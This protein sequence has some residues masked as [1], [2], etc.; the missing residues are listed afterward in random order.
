MLRQRAMTQQDIDRELMQLNTMLFTAERLDNYVN[1][2]EVLDLNRYKV[3]N[4]AV[5]IKKMIRQKKFSKP[6]IFFSNKN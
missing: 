2:H 6:F 5:E 1:A 3:I 4:N